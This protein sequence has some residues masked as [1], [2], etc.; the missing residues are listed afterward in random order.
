M[1]K[2][3]AGKFFNPLFNIFRDNFDFGQSTENQPVRVGSGSR[4]ADHKQIRAQSKERG[5]QE[6]NQAA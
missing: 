2:I 4:S 3:G 6:V 5:Y 1:E